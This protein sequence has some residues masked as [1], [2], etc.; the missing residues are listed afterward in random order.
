MYTPSYVI[1]VTARTRV[2]PAVTGTWPG[3]LTLVWF[4][5][6]AWEYLYIGMIIA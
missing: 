1:T 4:I 2:E 6:Y 3:I 5:G